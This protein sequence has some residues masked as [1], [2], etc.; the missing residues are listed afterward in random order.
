MSDSEIAFEKLKISGEKEGMTETEQ[1]TAPIYPL[2][3]NWT[4]WYLNDERNKSWEDRLKKVYTFNTVSEF[5]ALYDAIRPPSGLNALCDYNVFRDDIQPMWEVPENS[6]GGRWLIV[7]DKGKTPE[8]VD[9]IWLEILMALVGEQFGKDMESICGLV[10]N[11]RG[12]GSKISVWTKDCNDDETN[13]RIGVVL[14]EKLMAASKDHSKPL[15]DVIRYEDH[16]S[17]QKKTSSVV[18]AKLSL[19]SSDAPVAEKS[20]V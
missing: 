14:K 20:A 2:K 3:R 8:M 6:N 19:H 1:T 18:K 5:W 12:K 11:V 15:F 10:C 16:E 4:W 17:C 13:M 7:I 9:A